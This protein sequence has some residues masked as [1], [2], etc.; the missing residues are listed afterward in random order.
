MDKSISLQELIVMAEEQCDGELCFAI[1]ENGVHYIVSIKK[2][3]AADEYISK[4]KA[5]M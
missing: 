2:Y 3:Q 1:G 5:L 4:L